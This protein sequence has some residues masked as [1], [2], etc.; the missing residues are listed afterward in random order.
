[1]IGQVEHVA[2]GMRIVLGKELV[3]RPSEHRSGNASAFRQVR[4]DGA[5]DAHKRRR[6]DRVAA[7]AHDP[8]DVVRM[9]S[10]RIHLAVDGRADV[11]AVPVVGRIVGVTTE[12]ANIMFTPLF[13]CTRIVGHAFR[14]RASGHWTHEMVPAVA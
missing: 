10:N 2:V 8:D 3:G 4:V 6:P 13:T 12:T 5:A 9:T 1:M 7:T 11:A 14:V